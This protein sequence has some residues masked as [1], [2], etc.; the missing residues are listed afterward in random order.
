MVRNRS[1][2]APNF[3]ADDERCI[4][5]NRGLLLLD[6]AHVAPSRSL[7]ERSGELGQLACGTDGVDFDAPVGKIAR[8]AGEPEIAS[9]A[10]REVAV[11]DAL[12]A[13]ADEPATAVLRLLR[14]LPNHIMHG[15][16]TDLP[17]CGLMRPKAQTRR[18]A[19]LTST[20]PERCRTLRSE[21]HTS[22]LQSH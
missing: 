4:I 11:A 17:V 22:E 21:E 7:T 9:G 8:I 2:A 16:N 1:A 6:R 13:S 14:H 12:Y 10:L 15:R 18:S 5:A 19:L 20:R 3:S